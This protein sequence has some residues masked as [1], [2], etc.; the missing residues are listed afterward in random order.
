MLDKLPELS[1]SPCIAEV[2]KEAWSEATSE[3]GLLNPDKTQYIWSSYAI[4]T[5]GR[6]SLALLGGRP[7]YQMPEARVEDC[8][9]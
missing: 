8:L 2:E 9:H 5:H 1:L 6:A 7:T 3:M 4:E